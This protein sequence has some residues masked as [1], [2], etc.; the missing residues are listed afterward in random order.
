M[1]DKQ[2]VQKTAKL[3]YSK[4]TPWSD[5]DVWHSYTFKSIKQIVETWLKIYSSKNALI[6][7]AGSGGTNYQV[8]RK[9]IHLDI[10]EK[11]ICN[12]DRYI[13]G[14]IESIDLPNA[15]VDGVV[16]VGS[17]LNYTDAQR[18]IAELSRILKPEGFLIL[19]FERSN[20][21]E[22]LCTKKYGKYIFRQ[23]YLYNNQRHL[24]WMYSENHIRQLLKL[25]NFYI[26]KY[27]RIHIISSLLY[28]LGMSEIIAAPFSRYD[29]ATQL[30]SYTFAHNTILL[31][32]KKTQE[33]LK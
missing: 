33:D 7:N 19:E 27:K 2:E 30:I 12:Y 15:S 29:Y 6:L 13:V 4:S 9:F 10:I 28:R 16:C 17:V 3:N 21:A 20:S 8:N 5:Q 14:S 11:Y 31:G 26:C 24:L 1:K 32:I 18:S 22:F 25:N 23:D